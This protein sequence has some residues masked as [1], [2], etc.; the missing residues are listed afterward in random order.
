MSQRLN[1][2]WSEAGG[3][4]RCVRAV[5]GGSPVS[6]LEQQTGKGFFLPSFT[7]TL[8]CSLPFRERGVRKRDGGHSH[9]MKRRRLADLLPLSIGIGE[10]AFF[11]YLSLGEA[12]SLCEADCGEPR[13][14]Q[15]KM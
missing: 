14:G 5:A 4:E 15:Q 13:V 10:S 8:L 3:Q 9:E 7:L 11:G 12:T 1:Q 6:L 2:L